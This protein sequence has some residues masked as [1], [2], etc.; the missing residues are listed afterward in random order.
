MSQQAGE[1][2]G[3]AR[4]LEKLLTRAYG[5]KA[6]GL[7]AKITFAEAQLG[8]ER[9]KQLRFV[10]SVRNRIAHEKDVDDHTMQCVRARSV[11]LIAFL[12]ELTRPKYPVASIPATLA[13][14][15]LALVV[16]LAKT[17]FR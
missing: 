13:I 10:A 6:L 7:H 1:V 2:I 5:A 16:L 4:D 14:L 11:E 17:A 12:T 15:L 8:P 9:V 3:Y